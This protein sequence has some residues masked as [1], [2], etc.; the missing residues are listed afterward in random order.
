MVFAA[1]AFASGHHAG[2]VVQAGGQAA[3]VRSAGR[4]SSDYR[5]ALFGRVADAGDRPE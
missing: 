2:Q 5:E 3:Q 4:Q 1:L